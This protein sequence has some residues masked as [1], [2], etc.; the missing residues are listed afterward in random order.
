MH[1]GG[2]SWHR[3]LGLQGIV[4]GYA[5][6]GD[7]DVDDRNPA[8][9]PVVADPVHPVGKADGGRGPRSFQAGKSR[10]IVHDVVRNQNLFPPARLE[11]ARGGVVEAAEDADPGEQQ[12]IGPI[13]EG[14]GRSRLGFRNRVG[15]GGRSVNRRLRPLACFP[16]RIRLLSDDRLGDQNATAKEESKNTD[17][18]VRHVRIVVGKKARAFAERKWQFVP[19][20]F[21]RFAVKSFQT[22]NFGS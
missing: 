13:P 1:H 12:H 11:I 4:P 10:G 17:G 14:M 21:A 2:S 5:E 7:S 19:A 15:L 20:V 9:D 3:V 18:M 22:V 6:P 16:W 8:F